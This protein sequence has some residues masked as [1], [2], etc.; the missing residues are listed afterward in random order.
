MRL[1][2]SMY[3][4][5]HVALVWL[6]RRLRSQKPV[7]CQGEQRILLT[8]T[9]YSDNWVLAHIRPLA[10]A[11]ATQEVRV[12]TTYE[13]AAVDGVTTIVPSDRMRR[14]FGDVGAR[15]LTFAREASRWQPDYAGGF[16]LLF[17]G[18]WA[19]FV[20]SLCGCRS[21]YFCVGGP[22]EVVDGGLMSE[23]RLF[24]RIETASPRIEKQLIRA[25]G[26]MDQVVTMGSSARSFFR[27]VGV[28]SP[29]DVVSGGLDLPEY[30]DPSRRVD[31]DV[32][33]VG[34]L[35]PI[36]R[37]DLFVEIL[38]SLRK[39]R[40]GVR[41]AIVGDGQMRAAIEA[42]I[43]RLQLQ[44]NIVLAGF[45]RDVSSWL[46]RSRVF[47]LTSDSEGLSLALME[48]MA[49]GL[50]AVVSAVGDLGDLVDTGVN[51]TLVT[52]RSAGSFAAAVEIFLSDERRL[53]ESSVAARQAAEAHAVDKCAERWSE[54]LQRDAGVL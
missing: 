37:V 52:D 17:N 51:G 29:V 34:R 22:A 1:I 38:V 21:M 13:F 53:S 54:I 26:Y 33:F 43:E 40:Q 8:G 14:V 36:K 2:L 48:A 3:L 50:P 7:R 11:S 18:L 6:L 9:F 24:E 31:F 41:A 44:E 49:T 39:K 30:F 15:L 23:N 45:Q 35:A 28:Q 19:S 27:Q 10:Q 20:A 32:I 47:V 16:H 4:A 12:V 46:Q 42:Q 5:I 25:V